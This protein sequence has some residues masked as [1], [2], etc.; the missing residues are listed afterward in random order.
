MM[1]TEEHVICR[2]SFS[3]AQDKGCDKKCEGADGSMLVLAALATGV[4][5]NII[6]M[7][8]GEQ[9]RKKTSVI[10]WI[11]NKNIMMVLIQRVQRFLGL[12]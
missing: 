3:G 4:V 12:N 9:K 7:G 2:L 8:G 11:N 10:I 1:D 5:Y 6:T